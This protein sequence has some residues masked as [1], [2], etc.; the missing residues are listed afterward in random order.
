MAHRY[1][2]R[3]EPIVPRLLRELVVDRRAPAPYDGDA[4]LLHLLRT[5]LGS[6][7]WRRLPSE[8]CH[9][10]SLAVVDRVQTR[11]GGLSELVCETVLPPPESAVRL[12]LESRTS[13]VLRRSIQRG[14]TDGTWTLRRYLSLDRFGARALVDLLAA[15]EAQ[16]GPLTP[17]A[18]PAVDAVALVGRLLATLAPRLPL[19]EDDAAALLQAEACGLPVPASPRWLASAAVGFGFNPPFRTIDLGSARLVV[20]VGEGA[21]ARA[22]YR[23]A[24]RLVQ[25]QGTATISDVAERL[26]VS[27]GVPLDR[28]FVTRVLTALPTFRWL[29]PPPAE[30]D[31][32]FWFIAHASPV[33]ADL[34]RIFA[35]T[36]EIS[37][38]RLWRAIFRDRAGPALSEETAARLTAPIPTAVVAGGAVRVARR[39]DRLSFLGAGEL[40][41]LRLLEDAKRPLT[42]SELR[43]AGRAAGL[44]APQTTWLLQRS[45]VFER[46][47]AGYQPLGALEQQGAS[48]AA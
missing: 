16:G 21:A 41:L 26:R 8:T 42:A 19:A 28:A 39:L 29:A 48:D 4:D 18:E 9:R 23:I 13:N 20:R 37:V 27:A 24:V 34:R 32:W 43:D 30:K 40:T 22:A 15:L 45:P 17:S 47:P 36:D 5:D 25:R 2:R 38:A 6:D 1:P 10:L 14:Q 12:T 7:A 3:G 11:L 46:G 31:G 44:S 33:L 35:V